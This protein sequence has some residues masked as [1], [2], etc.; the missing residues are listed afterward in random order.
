MSNPEVSQQC[1]QCGESYQFAKFDMLDEIPQS[2]PCRGCGFLLFMYTRFKLEA[3]NALLVS[4]PAMRKLM[5][6]GNTDK[7]N[8]Y[9]E[10]K[11]GLKRMKA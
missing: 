7:L 1:P 10:N 4:D 9:V 11:V 2:T 3:V 5:T 6:S 8:E